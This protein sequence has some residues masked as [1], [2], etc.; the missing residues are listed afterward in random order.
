MIELR[1]E[2]GRHAVQR[3]AALLGDGFQGDQRIE[4][5]AGKHHAGAVGDR[6]QIAEHH[7]EAVI[8]RHRNTEPVLRREPHR[9]ADE[10]AVVE[11]VV[12]RQRR[13]FGEAGGAGGELDVDRLV[14]L[15][16]RPELGNPLRF[17]FGAARQNLGEAERA[18]MPALAEED[19]RTQRRQPRRFELAGRG[20]AQFR[21]QLAQHADIVRS[22]E[23]L[24]ENERLAADLVERVFEL[25]DAISGID[26]DQDQP[27][28]GRGE[29]GQHPFRIVG[30]PDADA[31]AGMKPERQKS[32]GELVD[33]L[34]QFAVAQSHLL[35]A[36][37][38]SRAPWPIVADRIEKLPDRLADERLLARAVY[39]TQ[40][41]TGHSVSSQTFRRL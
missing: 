17:F 39:V 7:A 21:R 36:N 37:H 12:M 15:Q 5:L 13:T 16:L 32:G 1:D 27:R 19:D 22:L 29:L 31:V 2:H 18:G 23:T 8:K 25:G 20:M 26:I 9:L 33:L 3:R 41:E 4:P 14:E 38:Q 35:V 30:R 6:R 11:D 10:E 34:P 28:F 40:L 24:G